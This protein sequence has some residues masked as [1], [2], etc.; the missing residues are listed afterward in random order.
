MIPLATLAY[1]ITGLH[2]IIPVYTPIIEQKLT[3]IIFQV[4]FKHHLIARSGTVF[5]D[6]IIGENFT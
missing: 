5:I 4:I 2:V 1:P 3:W 6:S